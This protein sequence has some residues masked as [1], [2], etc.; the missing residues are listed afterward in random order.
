MYLFASG[1][2]TDSIVEESG[3][4]NGNGF[5]KIDTS[6]NATNTTVQKLSDDTYTL[7]VGSDSIAFSN[8]EK[9]AAGS[10]IN[11]LD[12][13]A[14]TAGVFV[15][16]TTHFAD[17]FTDITGFRNVIGSDFAD[18]LIGD[19]LANS[20]SG[21]KGNDQLTGSG[22]SDTING[23]TGH[24]TLT[25]VRDVNFVLTNAG[26]VVSGSGRV[27]NGHAVRHR[28]GNPRWRSEHE[29]SRRERLQAVA[30]DDGPGGTRFRCGGRSRGER[31]Q[32]AADQRHASQRELGRS[33][34]STTS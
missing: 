1:S 13:S 31:S 33:G 6:S 15:N 21:G 27:G 28:L 16:L 20:L 10:G 19:G 2:G 24:D 8:V 14:A 18:T 32:A 3:A 26:L 11:T 22:G 23:G 5:D 30:H 7:T 29:Q 34:H 12:Y 9:V 4:S 25:E 17:E